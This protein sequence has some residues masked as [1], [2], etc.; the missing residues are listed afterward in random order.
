MSCPE[1]I[2]E[3]M[4]VRTATHIL[5]LSTKSYA[6]HKTLQEFYEG[7]ADLADRYAEVYMGEN[8]VPRFPHAKIPTGS[9]AEVLEGFLD[10][11]RD[12]LEE[13]AD[14]KTKETILTEIEELVL[15][16]LYKLKLK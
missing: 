3:S 6:E 9:A 5:H 8:P 13:E 14:H 12:E 11:V 10:V 2:A 15:S 16:T 1:F 4:A 7:L